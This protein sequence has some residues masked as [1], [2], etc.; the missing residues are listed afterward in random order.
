MARPPRRHDWSP[1]RS[2]TGFGTFGAGHGPEFPATGHGT[3]FSGPPGARSAAGPTTR[4]A[5]F[6]AFIR[7]WAV[8]IAVLLITEYLQVTL[9]YEN[10]VGHAG[11]RSFTAAMLV[12]HLP[13]LVCIS[14]AAWAAARVHPEPQCAQPLRHAIAACAVPAVAQVLML[15]TQQDLPGPGIG[16]LGLW[17]S[18]AVLV[19]GCV[20]GWT[21]DRLQ[22]EHAS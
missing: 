15:A 19:T 6:F 16:A 20:L 4:A 2:R 21:A 12:V 9:V 7:A 22:R 8:G 17:L 18:T 14:L 13:N 11:P 1:P 5:G 3:E 10:A